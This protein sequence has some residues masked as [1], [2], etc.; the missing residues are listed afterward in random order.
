MP[1]AEPHYCIF[2]YGTLCRR[3]AN[4]QHQRLGPHAQYLGLATTKGQLF[5]I[6]RYPGL[7]LGGD[8]TVLGELYTLPQKHIAATL[9]ILDDYE[10]CTDNYPK[11]WEYTRMLCDCTDHK[12]QIWSAWTYIYCWPIEN[13][14]RVESGD[15]AEFLARR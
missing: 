11:P 6:E 2:V 15:Y 3:V 14:T 8:K 1:D 13:R 10:G 5:H 12:G 7:I 9:N 4:N